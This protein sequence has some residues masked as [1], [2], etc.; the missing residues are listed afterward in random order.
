M[1][2]HRHGLLAALTTVSGG[3]RAVLTTCADS[4]SQHRSAR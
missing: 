2:E 1:S 3:A 4:A